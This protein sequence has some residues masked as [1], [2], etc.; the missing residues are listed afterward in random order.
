MVAA[1]SPSSPFRLPAG[2]PNRAVSGATD[3]G[4]AGPLT[5]RRPVA[6]GQDWV[7]DAGSVPAALLDG[8]GDGNVELLR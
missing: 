1:G 4:H 8:N 6:P 7:K 3:E 2:P 5:E